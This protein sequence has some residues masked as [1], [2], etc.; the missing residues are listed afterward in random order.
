[1]GAGCRLTLVTDKSWHYLR[2]D[3]SILHH[4]R[5]RLVAHINRLIGIVARV[6]IHGLL[7]AL[8][9]PLYLTLADV[10]AIS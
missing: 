1:M 9:L 5:A 3:L 8:I 10:F 6:D 4:Y 2:L 7:E